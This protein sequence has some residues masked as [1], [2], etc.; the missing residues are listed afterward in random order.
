MY[1][2][3]LGD[4]RLRKF[5]LTWKYDTTLYGG[6]VRQRRLSIASRCMITSDL[7]RPL[8]LDP[9]LS[10][11]HLIKTNG[12]ATA[13]MGFTIQTHS[14]QCSYIILNAKLVRNTNNPAQRKRAQ[15]SWLIPSSF[16]LPDF[17]GSNSYC[18]KWLECLKL[19]DVGILRD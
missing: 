12:E 17:E 13:H 6:S 2:Y 10:R 9:N 18:K 8:C 3:E 5:Q 1:I 19:I 15:T 4:A 11:R 7:S 16:F 14:D